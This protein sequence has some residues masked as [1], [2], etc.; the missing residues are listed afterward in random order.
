MIIY[1]AF[2]R[3]AGRNTFAVS[4]ILVVVMGFAGLSVLLGRAV[5]GDLAPDILAIMV[6]FETLRRVDLLLALGL[7][8]GILF[9]LAR[10]YRDSEATVLAACGIGLT[11]LLRPAYLLAV[12]VVAVIA[13]MGIVIGPWTVRQM[14]QIKI[15]SQQ[16][17]Q[18]ADVAP[19][20]FNVLKGGR[21]FY[22]ERVDAES[23]ALGTVFIAGLTSDRNGITV[24]RGG[25]RH[26]DERGDRFL[27]LLDGAMYQGEAGKA[28]YSVARFEKL[29]V[30]LQ[31]APVV[32]PPLK[33]E[34]MTVREL[35]KRHDAAS[36]AELHWRLSKPIAALV[37][38]LFAMVLAYTGPRGGRVSNLFAAILVYFIYSNMLAFG[39]TMLKKGRVPEEVGL[40]WVHLIMLAVGIYL[41][42]RRA[43][44]R[45]LLS[46]PTL[47]LRRR[48]APAK[49]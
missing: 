20:T 1:R 19:G 44:N 28:D 4:L 23:G 30:R 2:A 27:V 32:T 39:Q 5:R 40:W 25:Y 36:I 22:V 9:T 43:M 6:G 34:F 46:W 12:A 38:V 37:L 10:W 33:T 8:L 31:G 45:P 24:A 49:A 13:L 21:T 17:G 18:S 48:S 35:I 47:F 7:Y 41:F 16:Q 15:D 3:E 26:T 29:H 42:R 11:R 14:E